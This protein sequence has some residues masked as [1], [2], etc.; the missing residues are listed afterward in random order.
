[1]LSTDDIATMKGAVGMKTPWQRAG[2]IFSIGAALLL[3]TSFSHAQTILLDQG[4][5][6]QVS[7][8]DVG[9]SWGGPDGLGGTATVPLFG[10]ALLSVDSNGM[11]TVIS[12]FGD[13]KQ[14]PIS[15]G[16]LNAVSRVPSGLLGSGRTL[17]ALDPY[18]GTSQDGALFAVN[19]SNGHRSILSDFGNPKQGLPLGVT[20]RSLVAFD[21]VFGQDTAIYVLDSNAGTNGHGLLT[22]VDPKTGHRTVLSDFGNSAQGQLGNNP[23]SIAIAPAGMFGLKPMLVVLDTVSGTN[24]AGVLL[25][26]DLSGNRTGFSDLG[27]LDQGAVQGFAPQRVAVFPGGPGQPAA[28]YVT[29]NL[30]AAL[31][32]IDPGSG[33]RTLVSAFGNGAQGP[34]NNPREIMTTESGDVLVSDDFIDYAISDNPP[35]PNLLLVNHVNGRRTVL[36]DCNN[37][38]LGP[39]LRPAGFTQLQ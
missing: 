2:C 25:L 36:S 38:T 34:G 11:R 27:S 1:M 18:G 39:C 20:P 22:K 8:Y 9:Y 17:L 7:T 37:T 31:F 5:G 26:V 15:S 19:P 29:D 6:T 16:H 33:N 32:R 14:G 28:I 35:L 24:R 23:A 3:A 30:V 10:G 21:G 4:V 12:D 13:P